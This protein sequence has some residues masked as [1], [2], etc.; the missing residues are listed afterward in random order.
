LLGFRR[1]HK[2][3]TEATILGFFSMGNRSG[4]RFDPFSAVD[5]GAVEP[6]DL[7]DVEEL[8]G[9]TVRYKRLLMKPGDVGGMSAGGSELVLSKDVLMTNRAGD[10]LE[11]RDAERTLVAQSIHRVEGEAGVRRVSGPIR[12]GEHYFPPD[13]FVEGIEGTFGTEVGG[14]L[15]DQDYGYYGQDELQSAGPGNPGTE[16]K[17]VNEDGEASVVFNDYREF[18]VV[19]LANGKQYHYVPS[20]RPDLSVED[21]KSPADVLVERRLE[22]SHSSD[23]T[24]EVLSE[25]DGFSVDR[26][27]PYIEQVA[28]TI[29]G[30]DLTSSKGQ[31][32]YGK[33]LKPK[34]FSDFLKFGRGKFSMTEIDRVNSDEYDTSA[35]A[36]LFR[37]RPPRSKGD[38]EFVM[39]VTKE[40]KAVLN[41]PGSATDD[42]TSGASNISVEANLDGAIKAFIGASNPDRV[43]AHITLDGGLHLSV[44][45]DAVGNVITTEFKGAVRNTFT[46]NPGDEDAAR[47]IEVKGEDRKSVTGAE[48]KTVSGAQIYEVSGAAQCQCDRRSVNAHSGYTLN[49]G[50]L[51]VLNTGKTQQTFA[52]QVQE[53]IATGGKLSNILAGGLI[54]NVAA[55]AVSHTAA[56]GATT[57]NNPAG[58]FNI[59]VGSGALAATTASGAVTLS[60]GAGALTASAG[61]GAVA[62]TAGLAMNLTATAILNQLGAVVNLGGGAVPGTLGVLRGFPAMPPNAPTLDPLTGLPLQGSS[63]VLSS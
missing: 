10:L 15:K 45:K 7:E 52:Q 12:R 27:T 60:T 28:G 42:Y 19:V 22:M 9:P 47:F 37:I 26:R 46:G 33:I 32:Q 59:T 35:G 38:S 36:Y 16:Y 54:S 8:V 31:R 18:P 14:Q 58:A 41:L 50:E 1:L 23:L 3:L 2:N 25:V 40:G 20:H 17:F 24:Q 6:D 39:A 11:L 29:V 55:G 13:I 44:G 34:L 56:A 49:T 53:T 61:G 43:S 51:N 62:V 57:F 30:N 5:P 63:V 4:L 48:R 21:A